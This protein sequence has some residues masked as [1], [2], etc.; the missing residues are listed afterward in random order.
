MVVN[1]CFIVKL[2]WFFQ[3][4]SSAIGRGWSVTGSWIEC[5][6]IIDDMICFNNTKSANKVG[7]VGDVLGLRIL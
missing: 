1:K 6:K 4:R 3:L 7:L 5:V 2:M